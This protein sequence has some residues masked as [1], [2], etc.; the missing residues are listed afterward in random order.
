M[1]RLAYTAANPVKDQLVERAVQWP[2]L[3]GYRH[4]LNQKPLRAKRPRFFFKRDSTLPAEVILEFKIPAELGDRDEILAELRE[5][6][7]TIERDCKVKRR[8][9]RVLGVRAILQ[10]GWKFSP[11]TKTTEK[12]NRPK[13]L[14][15]FAGL[16]QSRHEA[17]ESF[18]E[19]LASYREARSLWLAGQ[20]CVFPHGTYWMAHFTPATRAPMLAI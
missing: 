12:S 19:F 3:N 6:V 18:R 2:G 10:Q 14:P 17:M 7:E 1:G 13:I 8:G 5:R 20:S 11:A 9:G 4:L 15:R 16:S